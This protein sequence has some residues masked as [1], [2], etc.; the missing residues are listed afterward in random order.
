MCHAV[1]G[2]GRSSG[3]AWAS[4]RSA[5]SASAPRCR[6]SGARRTR[7]R[8]AR[9]SSPRHAPLPQR[10]VVDAF[11]GSE[12]VLPFTHVRRELYCQD[13]LQPRTDL[14]CCEVQNLQKTLPSVLQ[15][16]FVKQPAALAEAQAQRLRT[17]R[18][19]KHPKTPWKRTFRCHPPAATTT[20]IST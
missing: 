18:P 11:G 14:P 2:A 16:V 8:T 10:K 9:L 19:K 17:E 7:A 20:R 15:E 12:H 13:L 6:A 5:R 1:P 3:R 4:S